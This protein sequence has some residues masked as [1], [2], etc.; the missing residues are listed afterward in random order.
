MASYKCHVCGKWF[1]D[2]S[3]SLGVITCPECA[4][5]L[6]ETE[7]HNQEE[8][9]LEA[10]I[11]SIKYPNGPEDKIIKEF[12][13]TWDKLKEFAAKKEWPLSSKLAACLLKMGG[14]AEELIERKVFYEFMYN[15]LKSK[16]P[17]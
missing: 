7:Q 14:L 10:A 8:I 11:S 13:L 2:Y 17:K 3:G 5:K 12:D 6:G 16:E 4:K 1:E 9:E 15:K